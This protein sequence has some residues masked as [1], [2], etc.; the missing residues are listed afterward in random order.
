VLGLRDGD[1]LDV[2]LGLSDGGNVRAQYI[3]LGGSELRSVEGLASTRQIT[4]KSHENDPL[5]TP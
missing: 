3:A 5:L 1:A 4:H 2:L